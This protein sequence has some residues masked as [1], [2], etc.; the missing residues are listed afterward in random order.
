M[1]SKQQRKPYRGG[2]RALIFVM[3]ALGGLIFV[4]AIVGDKGFR[5]TLGAKRNYEQLEA[6]LS[7]A[8]EEN[9]QLREEA[10]RL[11]EDPAT[12]EDVARRDL[13]LMKPG[14]KI[15]VIREVPASHPEQ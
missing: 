2:R 7:K 11:R 14:E 10:R 9:A 8:R 3:L 15:F 13:G 12:I 6:A 4:D 5:A 1:G